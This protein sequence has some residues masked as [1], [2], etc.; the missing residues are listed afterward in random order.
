MKRGPQTAAKA[1]IIILLAL[2][3]VAMIFLGAWML[4]HQLA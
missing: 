2:T 3:L 1:L 4:V